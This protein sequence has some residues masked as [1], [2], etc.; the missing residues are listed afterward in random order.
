MKLYVQKLIEEVKKQN[1]TD[2]ETKT[3][4]HNLYRDFI[5]NKTELKE[6]YKELNLI[7]TKDLDNMNIGQLKHI[8]NPKTRYFDFNKCGYEFY[9]KLDFDRKY[10]DYLIDNSKEST[11]YTTKLIE[12]IKELDILPLKYYILEHIRIRNIST[13]LIDDDFDLILEYEDKYHLGNLRE[14]WRHAI[15]QSNLE[16][17]KG[18]F[19][20][21]DVIDWVEK[22]LKENLG[23]KYIHDEF[24]NSPLDEL[25][26]KIEEILVMLDKKIANSIKMNFLIY[27]YE[28]L[29]DNE[30]DKDK[31]KLRSILNS[32][33]KQLDALTIE[34]LRD[35]YKDNST[36]I[37]EFYSGY[38]SLLFSLLKEV[39]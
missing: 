19:D 22:F 26:F 24:E 25:M 36:I 1:F 4:I 10:L 8:D 15:I 23:V 32:L 5:I 13:R 29:N 21:M 17:G 16:N 38:T 33:Y 18:D 14:L 7:W 3:L 37:N 12:Y 30:Y 31:G 20:S 2:D 6:L 34:D 28:Y 35:F 27:D 11:G 39:V 9:E